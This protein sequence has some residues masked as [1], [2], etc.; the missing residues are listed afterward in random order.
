MIRLRRVLITFVI[1][2]MSRLKES[3][4]LRCVWGGVE[5]GGGLR[6]PRGRKESDGVEMMSVIMLTISSVIV[7]MSSLHESLDLR[8]GGRGKVA[9]G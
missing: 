8:G 3:P 5:R 9:K 6:L 4:D 2:C 1:A 7:C